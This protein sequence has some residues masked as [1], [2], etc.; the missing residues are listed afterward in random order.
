MGRMVVCVSLSFG[1]IGDGLGISVF[2]EDDYF[3]GFRT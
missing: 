2:C 3:M 1:G